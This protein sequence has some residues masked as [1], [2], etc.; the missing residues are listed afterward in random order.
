MNNLTKEQKNRAK[1]ALKTLFVGDSLAMPAH[2]FYSVYDIEKTFAGGITQLTA[3][4]K[5]HPSSIMSLH[6]TQAGGRRFAGK[7][8]SPKEIVGE[9]ILKGK[10]EFWGQPNQHYHQGMQAGENTL[11]AHCARVLMRH[12]IT[13]AGIYQ[14]EDFLADY[15]AFMT[16]YPPQHPDTYAESYHRGFF[17]NLEK[18]L[19]PQKCAA[20]THDTASIGGLVTLA[21]LFFASRCHGFNLSQVQEICQQHLYLTHPDSFLAKVA[22]IYVQLLDELWQR[23][24]NAS[25]AEIIARAGKQSGIDLPALLQKG[26]DDREVIGK[27]FSPACYITD[28]WPSV[29]Y[30]A[31]K[32]IHD[33]KQALLANTNLGGDN[34]HRGAALGTILG[35]IDG[36]SVEPWFAQLTEYKALNHEINQLISS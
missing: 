31:Y 20:N 1:A 9:V 26:R 29:L 8:T 36:S 18:G 32:Y 13:H 4:P 2:W 27:I 21:P 25:C 23:T 16:A 34:V 11:N 30:L 14:A 17:A 33:P 10:R 6:S 24:D 5:T 7:K 3:A 12:L 15:I 22:A 28:S 19:P 35:L